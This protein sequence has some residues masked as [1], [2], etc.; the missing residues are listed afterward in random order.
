MKGGW[1]LPIAAPSDP[2]VCTQAIHR[3]IHHFA[4]KLFSC[5]AR[6][7][8]TQ[9]PRKGAVPRIDGSLAVSRGL[10]DF[11]FKTKE[12]KA[13]QEQAVSAEPEVT[14]LERHSNDLFLVLACDGERGQ[15]QP[16]PACFHAQSGA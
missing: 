7:Q 12:G 11:D 16:P 6:L 1:V 15:V 14:V 4:F 3:T 2:V 10:G 8:V 9:K 5:G 13:P